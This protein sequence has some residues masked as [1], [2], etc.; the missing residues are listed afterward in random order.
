MEPD[1]RCQKKKLYLQPYLPFKTFIGSLDALSQGI[2]PKIDKTI[3][4]TQSG[5]NQGLIMSAFRFFGL[6]DGT[7]QP[8]LFLQN[9]VS[10]PERRPDEIRQLLT[11]AFHKIIDGDLS[12]MTLRILEEQ[13]EQYGVSGATKRK[14]ITFFLQ[15][16]KYADLPLSSFLQTQVRTLSPLSRRRKAVRPKSEHTEDEMGAVLP[17]PEEGAGVGSSKVVHLR[18][19]G[20]VRISVSADV[21]S[22]DS[23][24]REFVFKLIDMLQDFDVRREK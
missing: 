15:A 17:E 5:L 1:R 9:L 14:A 8:T 11:N 3:W 18:S 7:D 19:G 21:F 13:M 6:V 22:M 24:D 10:R 4:R 2:P 23:Q 16:A 12:R 20:Y